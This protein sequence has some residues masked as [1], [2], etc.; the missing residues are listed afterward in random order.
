MFYNFFK[1]FI[2]YVKYPKFFPNFFFQII[3]KIKNLFFKKKDLYLSKQYQKII[4]KKKITNKIF[5]IKAGHNAYQNFFQTKLYKVAENKFRKN[6]HF[7]G[8][9]GNIDLL[10]NLAKKKNYKKFLDCG[11][12]AGWSSLAILD[13]IKDKKFNLLISNDMPY[14][15]K[16]NHK[17]V[18]FLIPSELKKKWILFRMPDRL[19]L[20][21]IFLNYG[22]FDLCHYDSDKTYFGRLWSYEL[23]YKNLNKDGLLI[24]DDINDNDAFID[25]AKKIKKNFYVIK[26]SKNFVGVII[27]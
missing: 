27:K 13:A 9:A 11:V 22:K 5:F 2:W 3:N 6:D 20:K 23:I 1:Y 7:M 21:K 19:I 14:M 25:F 24:S 12:A 18:G 10:S 15:F 4:N 17:K 16:N 8:G 26:D